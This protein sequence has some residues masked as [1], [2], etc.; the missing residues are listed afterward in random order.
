MNELITFPLT[1]GIEYC[2]VHLN[3]SGLT[4]NMGLGADMSVEQSFLGY[5]LESLKTK[6]D[7]CYIVDFGNCEGAINTTSDI[8]REF[9]NPKY[10]LIAPSKLKDAFERNKLGIYK[11]YGQGVTQLYSIVFDKNNSFYTDFKQ[12]EGQMKGGDQRFFFH[13][14]ILT[15]YFYNDIKSN[16]Q[17]SFDKGKLKYLESSNIYV[18]KYI[19][20]KSLFMDCK[21]MIMIVKD[22]AEIL[23]REFKNDLDNI[24]LLGV[25]N[26]GII[27]ANLLSYELKLP[28][29]SLNRLG[30]IYCL[31][32]ERD[33]TEQFN[34]K[35]CVLVSDVVCLGGEYR[36][37][38]GIVDILGATLVGGICVVKI[39]DVYRNRK[40]KN[41]FALLEDINAIKINNEIV[42]YRVFADDN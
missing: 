25:S 6:T 34:N 1:D 37:A 10:I 3:S 5:L 36:M 30:P 7:V 16:P 21:Y 31:N 15:R 23:K 41:V 22:L 20:I 28:V 2:S 42:D 33:K 11:A 26:N 27:L 17:Y 14:F 8:I 32:K 35:K 24:A 13:Q 40:E 4:Y 12:I 18:N 19:N 29:K 38:Q 9:A 39:R